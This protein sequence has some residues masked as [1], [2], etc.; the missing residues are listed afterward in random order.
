M[1]VLYF[2]MFKFLGPLC[3]CVPKKKEKF[4]YEYFVFYFS[5]RPTDFDFLAVIGKGTF[6]KVTLHLFSYIFLFLFF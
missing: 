3:N 6:G 5:A 4:L 2:H 1:F